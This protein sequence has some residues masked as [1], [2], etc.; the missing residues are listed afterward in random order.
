MKLIIIL[1]VILIL[2]HQTILL[3]NID[4]KLSKLKF[5]KINNL[6]LIQTIIISL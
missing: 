4:L 3:I 5:K 1:L 2:K 6:S